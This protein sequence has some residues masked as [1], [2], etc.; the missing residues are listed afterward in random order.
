VPDAIQKF[1]KI[2]T[3]QKQE[4][5][6]EHLRTEGKLSETTATFLLARWLN[7]LI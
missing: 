7:L 2:M 4:K 5:L 1:A 6:K 3:K